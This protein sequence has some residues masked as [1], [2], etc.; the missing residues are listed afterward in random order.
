MSASMRTNRPRYRLRN[1]M[2]ETLCLALGFVLLIWSLLPVYNMVMIALSE[3][4]DVFSGSIWPEHPSFASFVVVWTEG[5]WY[6]SRFWHQFGNSFFVGLMTM[7]AAD[8]CRAADLRHPGL[9]PG[10]PVLSDH[11]GLRTRR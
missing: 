11:A 4:G 2:E 8:Q 10:D 9:V 1:A 5:F 6:L 3:H 7:V